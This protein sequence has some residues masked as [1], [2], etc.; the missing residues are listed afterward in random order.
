MPTG[1]QALWPRP[2]LRPKPAAYGVAGLRSENGQRS[3]NHAL[4]T[5]LLASEPRLAAIPL[6][7]YLLF[8]SHPVPARPSGLRPGQGSSCYD[9][10]RCFPR[11]R[12]TDIDVDTRWRNS[13]VARLRQLGP[14]SLAGRPFIKISSG[15]REAK[16]LPSSGCT[17]LGPALTADVDPLSRVA[18]LGLLRYPIRTNQFA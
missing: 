15:G 4:M 6:S 7:M 13:P 1:G 9:L 14:Q 16:S 11:L 12:A 8:P 17:H 5:E 10:G 18:S 2:Q 3:T